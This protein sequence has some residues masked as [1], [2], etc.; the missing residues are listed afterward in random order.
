MKLYN[1]YSYYFKV[2][3]KLVQKIITHNSLSTFLP[4]GLCKTFPEKKLGA[5]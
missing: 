2:I 1:V 3:Y 5:W 4:E